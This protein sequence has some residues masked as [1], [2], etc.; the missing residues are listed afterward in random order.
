MLLSKGK[1]SYQ[2]ALNET[3]PK[4]QQSQPT[5][6]KMAYSK[7]RLKLKHTAFIELNQTTVVDVMY[8]DGDY[9]TWQ[10]HRIL[11]V[12]G[13]K[14]ILPTNDD[15]IREFGTIAYD[16]KQNYANSSGEHAVAVAS[17]LYDVLN[18][19]V[20]DALLEPVK[21]YEVD[22]AIQH[23]QHTK[24]NDLA[25]YDRGYCSFRM[26]AAAAQ[27]PGD[28]LIRVPK[29]RFAVSNT[30]FTGAGPDT[31]TTTLTAPAGFTNDPENRGLATTLT[32]RFVRVILGDGS[33]E[34]LVTSL[35]D[36]ETYPA[37]GFKQL[38]YLRWGVETLYGV[39]KTRLGLENF[40]GYSA[41]SIRQDFFATIFLTGSETLLTMDA[42]EQL[43]KQPGGYPKKVNKAVS[44]NTI[45]HRAF[46]LYYSKMPSEQKLKELTALFQGSPTVVRKQRNPPRKHPSSH[47]ILGWWIRTRK[48]VF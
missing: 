11:A 30:M 20:I 47:K 17:V 5:V 32:V 15:T 21:S 7:A 48:E 19:V 40:S 16:N 23:L 27:A 3:I 12:D 18:R 1:R 34:V 28:F 22:L 26:M 38:Y 9:Q 24:Q 37:T 31:V 29:K 14:V 2:L 13:S 43:S 10:G 45:K 39:L 46:E 6:S 36:Q 41:E 25:I 8:G 44:F 42:D 33:I 35:L 4:L